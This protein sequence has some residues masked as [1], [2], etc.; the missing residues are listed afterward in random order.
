MFKTFFGNKST[1]DI[2]SFP[3]KTTFE[4]QPVGTREV[5]EK[6]EEVFRPFGR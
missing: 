4:F 2:P 5:M 6:S 3:P 1:W